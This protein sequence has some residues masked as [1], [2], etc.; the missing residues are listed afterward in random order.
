[1]MVGG[2]YPALNSSQVGEIK[3]PLPPIPEQ[4]A[5][6]GVLGVVDSAIELADSLLRKLS[7]SKR[8]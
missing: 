2:Q 3:L 4:R 8:V 6:V 5:I 1:M 7:V